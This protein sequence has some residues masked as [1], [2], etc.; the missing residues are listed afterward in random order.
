[1]AMVEGGK[2]PI[3]DR[4]DSSDIFDDTKSSLP[5]LLGFSK[6]FQEAYVSVGGSVHTLA[7]KLLNSHFFLNSYFVAG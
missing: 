5:E 3:I 6:D 1:M 2:T 4:D 7:E